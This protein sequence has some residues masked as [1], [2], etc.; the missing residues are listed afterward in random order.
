MPSDWI[1]NPEMMT[2]QQLEAKLHDLRE[3]HR[4]LDGA[5]AALQ[6]QRPHDQLS[7]MRLKRSKLLLK[8][9]IAYCQDL[10]TPD[11]IA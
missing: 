2:S 3:E 9:R 8:D 1:A 4:A 10:L 6:E 7:I 5:I 11:I